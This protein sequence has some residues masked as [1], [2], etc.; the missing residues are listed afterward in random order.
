MHM[1]CWK[2]VV[3]TICLLGTMAAPAVATRA[4]A[5]PPLSFFRLP[6]SVAGRPAF[7]DQLAEGGACD[8]SNDHCHA[9]GTSATANCST[10]AAPIPCVF[11]DYGATPNIGE[12]GAAGAYGATIF[13][14]ASVAQRYNRD[15]RDGAAQLTQ[16]GQTAPLL[17][18]ANP[19]DAVTEWLRGVAKKNGTSTLCVASGGVRYNA[20]MLNANIENFHSTMLPGSY[21]CSAE[22]HWVTRVLGALYARAQAAHGSGPPRATTSTTSPAAAFDPIV[23]QLAAA[24]IP[25][26][27]PSYL[28]AFN[29]TVYPAA[30]LGNAQTANFR[31]QAQLSNRP[32]CT[33]HYCEVWGMVGLS[34]VSLPSG[35]DRKVDLGALGSGYLYLNTGS[36]G[37]PSLTWIHGG[38]TYTVDAPNDVVNDQPGQAILIHIARS[39][40]HV[41]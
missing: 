17:P 8:A 27:L 4:A 22:Y 39:L 15:A 25:V 7:Y 6:A 23:P 34:G 28:P 40:V 10:Q 3:A 9:T 12:P 36:N 38:N 31:W 5:N 24:T 20:I 26:Y 30:S 13:A 37:G 33:V 19:V 18:I 16:D 1:R 14:S 32:N 11:Y 35:W 41:H 21:P 29:V 2:A